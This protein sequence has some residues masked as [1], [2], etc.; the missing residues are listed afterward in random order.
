MES[1]LKSIL[2]NVVYLNIETTGHDANSSEIIEISALKV[3][4]GIIE[5]CT[6]YIKPS[7]SNYDAIKELVGEKEANKVINGISL[8]IA[9]NSF[10]KYAKDL[11]I[12]IHNGDLY[13]PFLN[14]HMPDLNNDLLDLMELSAILEPWHKEY[15][16]NVLIR[17]V[18]SL[19]YINSA[20][21]KPKS[22]IYILNSLL[23][24][25]WNREENNS[26]RKKNS[27]Y[28]ILIQDYDLKNKWIWTKYLEKPIFFN[29]DEYN[30]VSYEEVRKE[31]VNLVDIKINYNEFEDLLKKNDIWNNGGDFGYEYRESQRDFSEIIR[32]NIEKDERVFIEA[33]T[34][35]GKTFAYVL[36]AAL[37]AYKN[38]RRNKSED[39]SFII[40]T[41]TKELQNQLIERDIPSIL[42]KL[43]LDK[44]LKFG[45]IKGKGNYICVERLIKNHSLKDSFQGILAEIFFK[46]L[47]ADGKYGDAENISLWAYNHFRLEEYLKEVLCDNDECNLEKC[48]RSC[49]LRKRY[50][51]IQ[52][53][54]ITVINHSL[55][56]S[57]PY[58]EKKKITHLIIDEA[59]NLM[60]KSYDFFSEE[61]K[62][63]DFLEFL[64][65]V[66]EKEPTIYRNLNNLN[67]SLGFREAIELDKIQ[68]LVNEIRTSIY[69]LHNNFY[70]L[71]IANGNYNFRTEFFLVNEDI[72]S[73]IRS[74]EPFISDIKERIYGL[75]SLLNKYF[76]NITMEGEEGKD[77]HEF[78]TISNYIT[79]LKSAFDIIDKFLEEPKES[80]DYAK[81]LE[82]SKEYNY[83]ILTNT[84]LKI[85]K[86]INENVLKD[87]KS[88]TFLSA[89]M[90]INNSFKKIKYTLGQHEAG[91]YI[92]PPTFKLKE[93][94]RIFSLKDVGHYNSPN[95]IKNSARFIYDSAKS[96]NGHIL[97][98][99]TN[100][101]RKKAVE[102]ELR[103]LT[104]GSRFEIH[105]NKKAIK[106]LS[107]KNR[108]VIILGSK[109]F[110]EGIDVPGD[111]L[112]CV[113]LD[114][115]PNKSIDDP[116]LKALTTYQNQSYNDVNYPQVC[117]KLKQVYG[118]LIRSVM[119]YGYFCVLDIGTNNNTKSKIEKDLCG[120]RIIDTSSSNILKMMKDDY[121]LWQVE[122]LKIIVKKIREDKKHE[123]DDFNKEALKRKSFWRVDDSN[124]KEVIY[125]NLNNSINV[126]KRR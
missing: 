36:I 28:K 21:E 115:I 81:I 122:N 114:K 48:H 60:E 22:L 101:L 11:P 25:Q 61:F 58:S 99:F 72:K 113:I 1:E 46:R 34:G 87:V 35:S 79:K 32:D 45:A 13:K 73:R 92:V 94:T 66:H 89:T 54:N 2:D 110:F 50:N 95:F 105:S 51:E 30:Y 121:K 125:K 57:W 100:N 52:S 71:K 29:Y 19:N 85:D 112:T 33:P 119:D 96:L 3:S 82:V 40:S 120:P 8:E 9:T 117:I 67:A 47:C 27:L 39:A 93:R 7:Y 10:K 63:D 38:M 20:L 70:E 62:S 18:T 106:Y 55:L 49:Y 23:C 116:L 26:R 124:F 111:G 90:R 98:L 109:G 68:Y 91:E 14:I 97:V 43:F 77:D 31:D 88:T 76:N 64:T 53:E 108:Q 103:N 15:A 80:K 65:L 56:A 84:P 107:D 118:R 12:I 83:F 41:D 24:R 16:A 59:H 86:L 104:K 4:N 37:E 74:I 42:Q 75:Y 78:L 69:I 5:P 17:C 6:F 44:A 123:I 102:E 126:P